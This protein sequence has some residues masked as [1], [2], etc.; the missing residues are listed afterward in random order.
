MTVVSASK[1][2]NDFA[3]CS[4]HTCSAGELIADTTIN[5]IPGKTLKCVHCKLKIYGEK[6]HK[7][8]AVL[9]SC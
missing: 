1:L 3:N 7:S 4:E 8:L 2:V 5:N 6:E 9:W